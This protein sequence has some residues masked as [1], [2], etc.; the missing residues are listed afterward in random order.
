M[1]AYPIGTSGQTLVFTQP[2][3]DR[4]SSYRQ[5]RSWQREAGGQLFARFDGTDIIVTEAT[6]PSPYDV[7]SRFGFRPNRRREQ[8][9]I[10][11]RHERGHHFIGDWHTH[12]ET[13]PHPSPVDTESMRDLV[14]RSRH[15]LNGFIMV[16]VGTRDAPHGL[17]VTFHSRAA[18]LHLKPEGAI[19]SLQAAGEGLPSA[20]SASGAASIRLL[21]P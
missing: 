1:I 21:K 4:F 16:I 15:Q 11:E 7:R 10:L 19:G 17:S 13:E 12:P 5:R 3:L 20:A 9:E 6:P 14:V 2:V 18:T 8:A